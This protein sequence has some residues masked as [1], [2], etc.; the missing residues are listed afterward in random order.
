MAKTLTVSI[1]TKI[2]KILLLKDG[3]VYLTQSTA[4][5]KVWNWPTMV[6]KN[7]FSILLGNSTLSKIEWYGSLESWSRSWVNHWRSLGLYHANLWIVRTAILSHKF[8][9]AEILI[10]HISGKIGKTG[11]IFVKLHWNLRWALKS[12][13]SP[14]GWLLLKI[15]DS[16]PNRLARAS[17]YHSVTSIKLLY[18]WK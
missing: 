8:W 5:L 10:T 12:L 18:G 3:D 14:S 2:L 16:D 15:G 9:L 6:D 7:M 13:D 4:I 1:F 11:K 17:W